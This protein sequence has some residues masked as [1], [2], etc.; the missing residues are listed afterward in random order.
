MGVKVD[1]TNVI[2]NSPKYIQ[3]NNETF[4]DFCLFFYEVIILP[5]ISANFQEMEFSDFK[6]MSRFIA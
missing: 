5:E 3:K 4:W 2:Q 6:V 1:T